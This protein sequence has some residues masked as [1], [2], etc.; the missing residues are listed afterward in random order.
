MDS[1]LGHKAIDYSKKGNVVVVSHLH[2]IVETI[3]TERGGSPGHLSNEGALGRFE[4]HSELGWSFF[5]G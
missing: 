1:E 2:Q 4:F 5:L 3:G